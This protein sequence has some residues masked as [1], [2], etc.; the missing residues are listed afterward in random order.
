MAIE[1]VHYE[2]VPIENS[3]IIIMEDY[4]GSFEIITPGTLLAMVDTGHYTFECQVMDRG[5]LDLRDRIQCRVIRDISNYN[6]RLEYMS[7]VLADLDTKTACHPSALDKYSETERQAKKAEHRRA[8]HLSV[9]YTAEHN[10][11]K[12]LMQRLSRMR[13]YQGPGIF[14]S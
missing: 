5:M 14:L 11:K 8:M 9:A 10:K 4:G 13:Q 7:D 2:A 3:Q 1:V 12:I 6:L